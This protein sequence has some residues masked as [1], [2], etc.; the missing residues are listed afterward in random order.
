MGKEDEARVVR[1]GVRVG[2]LG[3]SGFYWGEIGACKGSG[4]I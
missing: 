3:D 2:D 1:C 4:E